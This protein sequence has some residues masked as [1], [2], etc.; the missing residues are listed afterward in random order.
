MPL[1]ALR[2]RNAKP[3]LRPVKPNSKEGKSKLA[4]QKKPLG[5]PAD[6]DAELAET[7]RA[8]QSIPTDKL[9]K[10]ADGRGLYLE[11]DPSGGKYWR[12]KYRRAGKEKRISL[13]VYPD[14]SL[15]TAREEREKC[16]KQLAQGIDP[17]VARKAQK[18][19]KTTGAANSFEVIAREWLKE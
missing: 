2:V 10:M 7:E 19:A 18:A 13:G 9:Y 16:R 12:L 3:G 17:G 4:K 11:V 6:K 5:K 8:V 15:A 1:T 14:V